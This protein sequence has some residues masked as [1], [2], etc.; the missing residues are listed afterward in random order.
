M[1][2]FCVHVRMGLAQ[3]TFAQKRTLVEVLI[4]CVIVTNEEA[5][6]RYVIP[7]TR[8]GPRQRFCHLRIDYRRS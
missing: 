5:E 4:D 2:E 7:T 8:A 3:A 6:I 1:A